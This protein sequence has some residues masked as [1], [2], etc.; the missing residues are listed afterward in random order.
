MALEHLALA[1]VQCTIENAHS[2]QRTSAHRRPKPHSAVLQRPA[3]A[4]AEPRRPATQQRDRR[5]TT[6]MRLSKQ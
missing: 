4:G 5:P 6:R 3:S 1:D 2:D